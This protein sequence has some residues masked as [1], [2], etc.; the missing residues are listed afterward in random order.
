[1]IGDARD[2]EIPRSA[3]ARAA[4]ELRGFDALYHVAGGSGRSFGDGPLH[5][6]TDEGWTETLRLNLT[7][8]FLSNRAAVEHWL[9]HGR[10]G[11]VLNLGSVSGFSPSPRHFDTHAYAAA[12]AGLEGLTLAAA[13]YYAPHGI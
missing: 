12:K 1:M 5:S 9:K 2:P 3:I 7:S 8:A 4:A 11:S 10:P 13:A 6:T